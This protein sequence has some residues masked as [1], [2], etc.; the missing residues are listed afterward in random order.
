L[1]TAALL[2]TIRL[3]SLHCDGRYT[4]KQNDEEMKIAVKN[5]FQKQPPEIYK[6]AMH[7][8][9]CGSQLQNEMVPKMRNSNVNH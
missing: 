8:L 5:W 6:A 4:E 2:S 9:I 7:A 3:L 1:D